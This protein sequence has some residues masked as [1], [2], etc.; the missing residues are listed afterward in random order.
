MSTSLSIPS[1][2]FFRFILLFGCGGS[3]LLHTGFL[4]SFSEL[5]L[6]FIA[7]CGLLTTVLLLL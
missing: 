5:G 2:L 4:S 3:L 6:L 1:F 7:V